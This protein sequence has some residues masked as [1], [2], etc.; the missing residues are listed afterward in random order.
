[1]SKYSVPDERPSRPT[2]RGV[3]KNGEK[4]SDKINYTLFIQDEL[5][6]L[7]TP[8]HNLPQDC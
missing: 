7:Y 3:E 5:R 6:K 1:M 2:T 8:I 4:E